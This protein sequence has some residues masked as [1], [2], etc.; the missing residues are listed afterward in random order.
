M[1]RGKRDPTTF[2]L[3]AL[4]HCDWLAKQGRA[5][6]EKYLLGALKHCDWLTK[7]DMQVLLGASLEATVGE[8]QCRRADVEKYQ[9]KYM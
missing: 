7:Q 6:V 3:F 2:P 1:K 9:Q 5:D 8:A 4:K